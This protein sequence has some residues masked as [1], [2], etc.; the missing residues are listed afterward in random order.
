MKA[1][2]PKSQLNDS[3][4]NQFAVKRCVGELFEVGR[5]GFYAWPNKGKFCCFSSHPVIIS[6]NRVTDK[7]F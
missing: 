5:R 7:F 4:S 6:W 3:H 2:F 1:E